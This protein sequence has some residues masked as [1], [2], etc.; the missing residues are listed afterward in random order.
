M[1]TIWK[2]LVKILLEKINYLTWESLRLK[3]TLSFKLVNT[4][5]LQECITFEIRIGRK[6]CKSICL[7]RSPSQTNDEFE[8]FLKIFEL[9]L[10]KIHEGNPFL[11]S[12][13]GDFNGKSNIWCKNNITSNE[14]SM[15]DVVTSNYG[16]HQ[17]IQ[18][19][20]QILNWT[21]SCMNLVFTSQPNLILHRLNAT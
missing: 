13:L 6:C 8:S 7:Y 16:L 18:I 20:T 11:I 19:L 12:V 5:H 21:F 1:A 15:I 9:T 3:N 2:Y 17:L 10:D 14:G 4:K